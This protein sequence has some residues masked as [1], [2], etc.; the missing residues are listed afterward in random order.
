MLF[1]VKSQIA[2]LIFAYGNCYDEKQYKN[3]TFFVHIYAYAL[4]VSKPECTAAL[5]DLTRF[6]TRRK[7]IYAPEVE[8]CA[9]FPVKSQSAVLIFDTELSDDIFAFGNRYDEK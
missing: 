4:Q 6:R 1:L 2:V 9:V 8:L 5:C 7:S 3:C